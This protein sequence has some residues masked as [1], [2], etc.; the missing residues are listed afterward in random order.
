MAEAPAVQDKQGSEE[1]TDC[2]IVALLPEHVFVCNRECHSRSK[3]MQ[4]WPI[5]RC[6]AQKLTGMCSA[7]CVCHQSP[8][9]SQQLIV[10]QSAPAESSHPV[11]QLHSVS[12]TA[13]LAANSQA[14]GLSRAELIAT[15]QLHSVSHT[16]AVSSQ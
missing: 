1:G 13:A 9:S 15:P 8:V 14:A 11:T 7:A 12:H 4:R 16:A 2:C 3:G 6:D 5:P 10:A